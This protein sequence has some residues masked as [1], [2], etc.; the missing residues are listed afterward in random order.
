MLPHGYAHGR[1]VHSA[2]YPTHRRRF[3]CYGRHHAT[4]RCLG[5]GRSAHCGRYIRCWRNC[6][7][8][9]KICAHAIARYSYGQGLTPAASPQKSPSTNQAAT[10]QSAP[11]RAQERRA[12]AYAKIMEGERFLLSLRGNP[13]DATTRTAAQSAFQE[14]AQL[15]PTIAETHTALAEIA[16]FFQPQDLEL[17]LRE[18]TAA[19]RIDHNNF[20]AH[21]LLSRIYAL[22]SGL[23][24]NNLERNAAEQATAELRE[25]VRLNSNDAEAWGLLGELYQ[26]LGKT[27]DAI[28]AF[29]RWAEAP[30]PIDARIFQIITGR[31]NSPAAASARLG[32]VM[33]EAGRAD[34]AVNAIRSAITLDPENEEYAELL[35]QA[36]EAEGTDDN[37]AITE[38]QS[39]AAAS[40]KNF[41]LL[42]LLASEQ[43]R[44][45]QT[46][47][48]AQTLRTAIEAAADNPEQQFLLRVA[49]A[50]LYADA[51]RYT[52]A[53]A[54]YETLLQERGI[55]NKP[56]TTDA[57]KRYAVAILSSIISIQKNAGHTDDALAT[58]ERMRTLL[59]ADSA[60]ADVQ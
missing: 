44:A 34:D 22:K 36:L 8:P 53:V 38:L 31:E 32:E 55:T 57:E 23:R 47:A 18:A 6:A 59:G 24:E 5:G 54:A 17:A 20:G 49:L 33:L 42:R 50:E 9:H 12:Q 4:R 29:S 30:E 14:A 3:P 60:A 13:T 11:Q 51:L 2:H 41:T 43:S 46:D 26:R 10:E 25:V 37:S 16:L 56:L 52:D 19:T 21:K 45:G 40:P 58:I 39:L 35:G 7:S 28:E 1:R 48:A 15:D 27:S